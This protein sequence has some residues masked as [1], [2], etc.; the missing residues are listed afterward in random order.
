VRVPKKIR[1]IFYNSFLGEIYIRIVLWWD[2][3]KFRLEL[4]RRPPR[5][6]ASIVMSMSQM[7][8]TEGLRGMRDKVHKLVNTK[9]SEEFDKGM[10]ELDDFIA[11]ADNTK[12]KGDI[13]AA[14]LWK[15]M[16]V[17]TGADI[18]NEE[19]KTRMIQGRI[20]DYKELQNYKLEKNFIR[21][22]KTARESG[23]SKL[24]DKLEKEWHEKFRRSKRKLRK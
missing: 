13:E 24:A 5:E 10:K 15:V 12:N 6:A 2:Y 18:K 20:A 19:A 3:R 7:Y 4:K 1:S 11:L 17:N 21:N 22:I 9:D 14:K 8:Y 23:N 16:L